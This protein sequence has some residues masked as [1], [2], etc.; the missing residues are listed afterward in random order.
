M[1]DSCRDIMSRVGIEEVVTGLDSVYWRLR[2]LLR[3][4]F[5]ERFVLEAA[6]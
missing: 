4:S 3:Y 5:C 2:G 1:V 6:S